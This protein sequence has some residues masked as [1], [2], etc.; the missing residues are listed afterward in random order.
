LPQRYHILIAILAVKPLNPEELRSD[1]FIVAV[2]RGSVSHIKRYP[3]AV[4]KFPRCSFRYLGQENI[5]AGMLM[6]LNRN[7]WFM[8]GLLLLFV[9]I[10]FRAVETF[11]LNEKTSRFL[12]ERV[13]PAVAETGFMASVGPTPKKS[14]KPPNWL[15][16]AMISVGSVLVLHA[17]AMKKP[18][19]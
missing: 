3:A 5:C 10:Q 19:G 1:S 14:L 11:V 6:E 9:G 7:N 13:R 12:A 4:L 2:V 18:G 16:F 17:L 15:G 8:I